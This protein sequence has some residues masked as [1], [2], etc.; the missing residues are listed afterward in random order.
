VVW[1]G[2]TPRSLRASSG[3]VAGARREILA[4]PRLTNL[5]THLHWNVCKMGVEAE[6]LQLV[7]M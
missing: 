4:P 7:R 2:A 6:V 5:I 1:T 3:V